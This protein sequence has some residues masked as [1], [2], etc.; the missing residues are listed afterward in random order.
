M[1]KVIYCLNGILKVFDGKNLPNEMIEK[2]SE[3]IGKK[4]SFQEI[5]GRYLFQETN[6]MASD[7]KILT[8]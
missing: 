3:F 5:F 7:R 6:L 8:S 2:T 1:K 4:L